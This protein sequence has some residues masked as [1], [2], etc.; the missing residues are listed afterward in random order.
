MF[1][2]PRFRLLL[3]SLCCLLLP[4]APALRAG[5]VFT[6]PATS[7]LVRV[8][9]DY[10]SGDPIFYDSSFT[11]GA[12]VGVNAAAAGRDRAVREPLGLAYHLGVGLGVDV[13][14]RVEAS[15]GYATERRTYLRHGAG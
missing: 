1:R 2:M 15:F 8:S 11:Y 9:D 6:D 13:G 3:G 14:A 12:G 10:G 5:S 4:L 7:L